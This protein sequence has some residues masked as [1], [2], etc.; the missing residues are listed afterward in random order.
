[1]PNPKGC[2]TVSSVVP[3][4]LAAGIDAL[5]GQSGMSRS[6]YVRELL[7][8]AVRNRRIFSLHIQDCAIAQSTVIPLVFQAF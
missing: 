4:T 2:E 5:A 1:M 7:E 8:D 6:R 3:H